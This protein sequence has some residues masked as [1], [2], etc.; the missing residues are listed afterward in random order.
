MD[1]VFLVTS[2]TA[3]GK[4]SLQYL[5]SVLGGG[6]ERTNMLLFESFVEVCGGAGDGPVDLSQDYLSEIKSGKSCI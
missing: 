6:G 2:N 4:Y 3:V 1:R 5:M